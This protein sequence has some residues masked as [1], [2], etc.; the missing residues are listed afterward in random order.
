MKTKEYVLQYKVKRR[1]SEWINYIV[2]LD[3]P[4]SLLARYQAILDRVDASWFKNKRVRVIYRERLEE[5]IVT[6]DDQ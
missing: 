2:H 5:V 1:G 3:S 6:Q 4:E